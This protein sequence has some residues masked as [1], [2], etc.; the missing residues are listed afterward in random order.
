MISYYMTSE[1]GEFWKRGGITTANLANEAKLIESDSVKRAD[2]LSASIFPKETN[3]AF[4][5]ISH[6][7]D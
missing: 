4:G 3:C 2:A 1:I 7:R 5:L 6:N